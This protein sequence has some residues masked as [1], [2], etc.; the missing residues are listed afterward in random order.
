VVVPFWTQTGEQT[1]AALFAI[2]R[3]PFTVRHLPSAICHLPCRAA[4]LADRRPDSSSSPAFKHFRYASLRGPLAPPSGA[5]SCTNSSSRYQQIGKLPLQGSGS[6]GFGGFVVGFGLLPHQ[7]DGS[8]SLPALTPSS[9]TTR[10]S[11]PASRTAQLE[12]V[13]GVLNPSSLQLSS[14]FNSSILYIL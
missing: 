7:P 13:G 6:S 14:I 8:C 1:T 12:S 10:S 3:L 2:Y 5:R 11:I 9:M 4:R